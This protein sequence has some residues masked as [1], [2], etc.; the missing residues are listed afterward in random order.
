MNLKK[1]L[2]SVLSLFL[3]GNNIYAVEETQ[4]LRTLFQNNKAIIYS[5]NLRTFNAN[6]KNG[7]GIIDFTLGET[8]GN[9]I[10]A[11]NRLDEIKELG[12]NAIH[13][14]PITPTGKIKS[15]GTA[16]SLYALADFT[17]IN[18]QLIDQTSELSSREQAKYFINECH[19]RDIKVI[20]DLPSCGAYDLF[21][22][23]PNLFITNDDDSA[24]VPSDWTDVRLFKVSNDETTMLKSDIYRLHQ[25]YI[26]SMIELG[27]DGI[28]V[29]GA[30]IKPYIFWKNLLNF[31]RKKKNNLMFFAEAYPD[32]G[33]IISTEAYYTDY[34]S[35]LD[36]GFDGFY[37]G[38]SN[39]K[40]WN[41]M[42]DLTEA[43]NNNQNTF[44]KYKEKKSVIGS[45]AT[46]DV[47]SPLITGG[48]NYSK[49]I[50]WL[51]ATLP[52]NPYYVDGFLQADD[53]IYDYS[54]KKASETFTDDDYYYVHQGQIDIF[55]FS[56]KPISDSKNLI[57]EQKLA[58]RLRKDYEKEITEGSF[59]S[60]KSNN[61]KIFAYQRNIKNNSVVIIINR[62]LVNSEEIKVKIKKLKKNSTINF[63]KQAK[64]AK[65]V[66][67]TFEGKLKPSEI[68]VFTIK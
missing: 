19:K 11:V 36:A 47:V 28:R 45:F 60:L 17:T 57:N 27:I 58:M 38:F 53:Y 61:N 30:K 63:I 23:R 35:L 42:N 18:T 62:N 29:D 22:N 9:F 2:F 41:T 46:H 43:I 25:A 56:R 16:G 68:V 66:N 40:N 26:I 39:L 6:D 67:S 20:V 4:D 48:E 7:N 31:A 50:I 1:A 65:L 34:K 51:N 24:I 49:L 54:N 5:I 21:L 33:E 3:I 44:K 52:L 32:R 10:N 55:N 37:G 14:L 64:E 13:L 12:I 59:I 15:L 8:S